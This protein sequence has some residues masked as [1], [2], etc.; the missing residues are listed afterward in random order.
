MKPDAAAPPPP[1]W[2][3]TPGS[4]ARRTIVQRKHAIIGDLLAGAGLAPG[5]ESELRRLAEE[6][7]RGR[8]SDPWAGGRGP[9]L[10]IGRA[11]V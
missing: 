1:L 9:R 7:R 6:I 4:F 8:L 2:T 3:G 11:H 5:S 10:Q